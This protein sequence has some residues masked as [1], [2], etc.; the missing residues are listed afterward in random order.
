MRIS[1]ISTVEWVLATDKLPPLFL[2]VLSG[3]D[4]RV[5]YYD[6]HCWRNKVD[7][8][9][10]KV[11]YW[12]LMPT[13]NSVTLSTECSNCAVLRKEIKELREWKEERE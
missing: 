5:V 7:N 13:I 1:M 2:F 3:C 4:G 11:K 12:A 8:S 9:Y 10:G 6:G